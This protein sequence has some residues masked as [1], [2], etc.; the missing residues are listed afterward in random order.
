MP[1]QEQQQQP[2]PS[3]LELRPQD[4]ALAAIVV[5]RPTQKGEKFWIGPTLGSRRRGGHGYGDGGRMNMQ[6]GIIYA[7]F[8]HIN[9]GKVPG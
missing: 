2:R 9:R 1:R 6:Y 8:G 3:T 4:A 5:A 7:N